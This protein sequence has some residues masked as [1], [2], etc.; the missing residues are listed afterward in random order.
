LFS[1]VA[2]VSGPAGTLS[3]GIFCGKRVLFFQGRFGDAVGMST[4]PCYLGMETIAVSVISNLATGVGNEQLRHEDVVSR[5]HA[6]SVKI[7]LLCRE[8]I[9]LCWPV[10]TCPCHDN[11]I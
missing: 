2:E 4:V 9:A 7:S 11:S 1:Q 10:S 6:A 5:G 3:T 8:L